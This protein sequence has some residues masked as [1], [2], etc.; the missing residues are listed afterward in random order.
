ML[1]LSRVEIDLKTIVIY[2]WGRRVWILVQI[3]GISRVELLRHCPIPRIEGW[4]GL[5]VKSLLHNLVV[6]VVRCHLSKTKLA[7][8]L[9]S[10]LILD[11]LKLFSTH[12][13]LK[14][15]VT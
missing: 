6:C 2:H 8:H 13:V 14:F 4:L 1:K 15:P 11:R 12:R 10:K 5:L 9:L 3:I 7:L